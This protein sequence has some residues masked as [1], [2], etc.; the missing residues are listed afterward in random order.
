MSGPLRVM[1]VDDHA[2]VRSAVRGALQAPDIEIVA[3]ASS[4]E[5]AFDMALQTR[6][7]IILLDVDMPGMSGLQLIR[8]LQPRLP[9]TH[10]VMLSVSGDERNVLEAMRHGAAGYLTKD[11]GPEALQR[12]VRGIPKGDLAMSQKRYRDALGLYRKASVNGANSQLVLGQYHAARLVGESHPEAVLET[13]LAANPGDVGVASVLGEQRRAAGNLEGAIAVYEATLAKAPENP[14][15]LN[16]LSMLYD[17]KKDSA[18][19][20][21]YASRA[22]KAAPGAPAIADTYGW[23]LF[24][25]GKS[26]EALPL[27]ESAAKGL[28]DNAEV[29]Y[30]LGAVLAK[31]GNK[32]E[33]MRLLKKAVAGQMPADQKAD[34]Q[35]LLQQLS[36]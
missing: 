29:Q 18:K 32:E 33:A 1:L 13:W 30:H 26:A 21:N 31:N 11:L 22:Y 8:E 35:K 9:D 28:P 34:A 3:E 4:A 19:A 16:N 10:I 23:M 20:L 7:Q 27:I 17:V 6:P 36:K 24:K 12:A 2:L 5:A 15:A 14:I 25:Q